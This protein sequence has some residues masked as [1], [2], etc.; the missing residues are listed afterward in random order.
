M[1]P[2]KTTGLFTVAA[3]WLMTATWA[4]AETPAGKTAPHISE[5]DEFIRIKIYQLVVDPTNQQPVIS[6][7]DPE[8][9]RILLIWIGL[10][11][12]TAIYSELQ[13]I[14]HKRPLTHDLL[15]GVIDKFNGRI[16][17]I[18]ITRTE[19]SVF[20]AVIVLRN[21]ETVVEIDA[22]PSDSIVMALKF[23]API[24]VSRA[25]FKKMSIPIEQ[26]QEIEEVYGLHLQELTTELTKYLSFEATG[27][28]MV[29][30]VREGSRAAK[31]GIETGDIIVEVGEQVVKNASDMKEAMANRKTSVSARI[32][33]KHRFL[34]ITLHPR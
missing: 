10:A 19:E 27:G 20:Y 18:V 5:H 2:Q 26:N 7:S 9:K 16:D 13:G 8:E 21:F 22:R 4:Y 6:L 34:T 23:N 28:V 12:A 33:R 31:D 32:F 11:E 15:A 24:F 25:L 3:L 17:R 1:I 29:A 30:G 14:A